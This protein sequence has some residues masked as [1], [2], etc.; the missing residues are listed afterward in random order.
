MEAK[1]SAIKEVIIHEIEKGQA[2]WEMVQDGYAGDIEA[3]IEDY[4][5]DYSAEETEDGIIVRHVA[6]VG[7]TWLVTA[8]GIEESF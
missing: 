4:I 7:K 5:G 1:R 2:A 6:M 8:T 3:Y